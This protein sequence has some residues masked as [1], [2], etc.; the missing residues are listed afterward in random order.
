MRCVSSLL[1]YTGVAFVV[2]LHCQYAVAFED[3]FDDGND[4]G[5]THFDPLAEIQLAEAAPLKFENGF[6]LM[7]ANPP[8]ADPAGPARISS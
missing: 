1:C 8:G 2:A 4:E 7:E 6:F 5:W 3:T